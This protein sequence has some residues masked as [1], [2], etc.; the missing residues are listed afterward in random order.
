MRINE[1]EIFK[2]G[3]PKIDYRTIGDTKIPLVV[4]DNFYQNPNTVRDFALSLPY[5]KSK[6]V[7][8]NSPGERVNLELDIRIIRDVTYKL[9]RLQTSNI[10]PNP[11]AVT[12][13]KMNGGEK[14][15]ALQINPH[16]DDINNLNTAMIVYLNKPNECEGGTAFYRH[17]RTGLEICKTQEQVA[18]TFDDFPKLTRTEYDDFITESNDEWELIDMVKMKYNRMIVYPPNVFHSAYL[19]KDNFLEYDRITQ[20]GFF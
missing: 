20:L 8:L 3:K 14:L 4:V 11:A 12:F 10:K 6:Y 15:E 17:K 18:S 5:T 9:M 19:T 13:N 2:L 7:C 1:Y 16:V